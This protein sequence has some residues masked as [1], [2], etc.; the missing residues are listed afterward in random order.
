MFRTFCY[1]HIFLF[2]NAVLFFNWFWKRGIWGILENDHYWTSM[3]P[4]SHSN[5]Y[6]WTSMPPISRYNSYYWTS[7]PIL[8]QSEKLLYVLSHPAGLLSR[9]NYD[10]W[11]FWTCSFSKSV[12]LS[13]FCHFSR[14]SS[15]GQTTLLTRRVSK[16]WVKPRSPFFEIFHHDPKTIG[17]PSNIVSWA[18]LQCFLKLP[19][20]PNFQFWSITVFW[21]R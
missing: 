17:Q 2:K 19:T 13:N 4:I 20:P 18:E 9:K 7:M 12:I 1:R 10:F 5:F 14:E 15:S 6:Y 11:K 8:R 3:P 16:F 21:G